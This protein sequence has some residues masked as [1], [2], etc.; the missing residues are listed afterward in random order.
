LSDFT[1][2]LI[3]GWVFDNYSKKTPL[4]VG[5]FVAGSAIV[6]MALVPKVPMYYIMRCLTTAG[7]VATIIS[8]LI[9]D[10]VQ[11]P[12]LGLAFGLNQ[13]LNTIAFMTA[14]SVLYQIDLQFLHDNLGLAFYIIGG[15]IIL[16]SIEMI[17]GI[18]D[19]KV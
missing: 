4:I 2:C 8:P 10:Y 14:S 12:S 6:M 15:F 1:V 7:R 19:I 16:V 5:Q 11:G 17:F 3:C 18:K 9:P 13:V